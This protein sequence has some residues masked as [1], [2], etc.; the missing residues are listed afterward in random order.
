MKT[1]LISHNPI[2][3]STI[4]SW[5]RIFSD[6]NEK[7]KRLFDYIICPIE[8]N[9]N[10][11][12]KHLNIKPCFLQRIKIV[13]KLFPNIRFYWYLKNVLHLLDKE[14]KLVLNIVDNVGVLLSIDKILTKRGV[15][16]RVKIIFHQRG[17]DYH[18]NSIKKNRFYKAIDHLILQTKS[19]YNYQISNTHDISCKISIVGNGVNSSVFNVPS[20]TLKNDLKIKLGF[21][22]DK[23]YFLWLSQDRKKKGLHIILDAWKTIVNKYD[24]VELVVI[25]AKQEVLGKGI[26]YIG[27]LPN[28][29][30]SNYYKALDFYLFSSLCHEGFSLS[31]T[32]ALKCGTFCIAS[33]IDPVGEILKGGNYGQLVDVPNSPESWI[34]GIENALH[35]F[36]N[37]GKVNPYIKNIPEMEYDIEVWVNKISEIIKR[38]RYN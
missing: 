14:D 11:S 32:E 20:P 29:E 13:N 3:T 22:P 4:G 6:L 26:R 31:L 21:D 33:N 10:I 36:I 30:V 23:F 5:K 9:Q 28:N 2:P 1:V 27:R 25:G 34:R 38:E 18:L 15:R 35:I 19:S 24:N 17:F 16:D 12:K 37:N 7:E 8:S